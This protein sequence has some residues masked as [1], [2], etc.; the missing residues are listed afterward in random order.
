[1]KIVKENFASHKFAYWWW[2]ESDIN[3]TE[4][5]FLYTLIL[6]HT[7]MVYIVDNKNF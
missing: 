5:Y 3:K 1:M 2:G 7:N 6:K 4:K